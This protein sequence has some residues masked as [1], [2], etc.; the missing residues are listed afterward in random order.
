[1]FSISYVCLSRDHSSE[2]PIKLTNRG[3]WFVKR[4]QINTFLF[5]SIFFK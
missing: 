3:D 1:M 4:N 2:N 5:I